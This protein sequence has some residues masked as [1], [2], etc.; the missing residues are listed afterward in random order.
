M[1]PIR[2]V[3]FTDTHLFGDAAGTLRG[4]ATL[5]TLRSVLN[6]AQSAIAAA[7]AVLVTGD[8]VQ[9]DPGGYAVFRRE[10]AALGKPILCIAGNHDAPVEMRRVL[11]GAPF[12]IDGEF[13]LG[14]WRLVMLD[15]FLAGSAAGRLSAAELAR[16]DRALAGAAAR[17][18][19]VCLHHHP[20]A[21]HSR[22]LDTVGLENPAELFATLARHA[23]VR[24][25]LWGHVHQTLDT[26]RGDLRLLATPSTC[27]QFLPYAED[28]ALDVRP[29]AWR[30]LTLHADGRIDT[31]VRWLAD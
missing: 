21:M 6:R 30:E 4:I 14:R 24:A 16:L 28:F 17:H 12:Q 29:P 20:V 26:T 22:W 7:E 8:L 9:D 2:L 10:F 11:A 1:D 27:A 15:S 25:L 13:D 31:E 3:Q 19:L 18:A 23:N 5:A